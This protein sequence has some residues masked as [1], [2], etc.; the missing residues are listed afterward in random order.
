MGAASW[1][2]QDALA[3]GFSSPPPPTPAG[4]TG[5]SSGAAGKRPQGRC[6]AQDAPPLARLINAS[7]VR[8]VGGLSRTV[9]RCAADR[10]RRLILRGINPGFIHL[11][12]GNPLPDAGMSL[13]SP[14]SRNCLGAYLIRQRLCE[15]VVEGLPVHPDDLLLAQGFDFDTS[16]LKEERVNRPGIQKP[17]NSIFLSI[18]QRRLN[19]G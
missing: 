14:K 8:A 1:F 13:R 6:S 17:V 16:P 18:P 2:F 19:H 7:L 9:K 11:E 12:S 3:S 10:A 4:A 5:W 15:G